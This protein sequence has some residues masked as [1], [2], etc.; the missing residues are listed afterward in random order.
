MSKLVDMID[1]S[2]KE[3]KFKC[4]VLKEG[5]LIYDKAAAITYHAGTT[6]KF[7]SRIHDLTILDP[8]NGTSI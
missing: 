8:D 4:I 5:M 2:S 7:Y 6:K 3:T 1:L